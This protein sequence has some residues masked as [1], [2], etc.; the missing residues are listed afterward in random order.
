LMDFKKKLDALKGKPTKKTI[1]KIPKRH[2]RSIPT[3][4]TEDKPPKKQPK[5]KPQDNDEKALVSLEK[6]AALAADERPQQTDISY[7]LEHLKSAPTKVP[8][9][10]GL[11]TNREDADHE[12]LDEAWIW[13]I[14]L[15]GDGTVGK[16]SVRA[17]Y[18]RRSF[19][20]SYIRTIGA[21]F[22]SKKANIAGQSV[23]F[24]IWD[25]AG[26]I[27]FENLRRLYYRGSKGALVIFDLTNRKSFEN[28]PRWISEVWS[29]NGLS[30]I[31]IVIL[32]NKNDL[33]LDQKPAA[34]PEEI[35][36]IIVK[37]NEFARK[38]FGFEV[39]YLTTSAKT[40]DNI[41]EAF[42]YLA[43]HIMAFQRYNRN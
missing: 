1:E 31:P 16:T 41:S 39:N 9:S 32:G 22:A 11:V 10:T 5:L 42:R 3:K 20:G 18:L 19:P 29:Y 24:Q 36:T 2:K 28:I 21:D 26:Q 27:K 40:G 43:T 8:A 37:I 30:T 14:A 13:K 15:C 35:N 12:S 34:S 23:E 6:K 25:I 38:K 33:I 17:R 7:L 4:K